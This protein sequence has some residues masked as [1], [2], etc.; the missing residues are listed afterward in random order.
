[1]HLTCWNN[2]YFV[3]FGIKAFFVVSKYNKKS[4]DPKAY[5]IQVVPAGQVHE[6][7]QLLF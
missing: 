1:M 4:F 7:Y 5:K 3:S 6:V 2:L